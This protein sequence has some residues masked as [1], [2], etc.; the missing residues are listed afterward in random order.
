MTT[1]NAQINPS[2]KIVAKTVTL[3]DVSAESVGL[4]NVDNTSDINKPISIAAQAALDLKADQATTYTK[5][6]VDNNIANLVDTAPATLDTLN[7][8]AAALGDDANFATS[9]TDS[10]A[11]KASQTDLDT[12]IGDANNPHA[13]TA[14]QVGLGSVDNTADIDKPISTAQQAVL[15]DKSDVGHTHTESEITDLDK[16]T[17]AEAN[18][19]FATAAQGA[20]AD[21]ATQPSD[22][23]NLA[24]VSS[25][26]INFPLIPSLN[27]AYSLGST[28]KIW[29]LSY[30]STAHAGI[31]QLN[32]GT[33]G[34]T[35]TTLTRSAAGVLAVEGVDV[36]TTTTGYTQA[37]ANAAFATAAQGVL[38][39]TAAQMDYQYGS[40]NPTLALV[41]G[42]TTYEQ[43]TYATRLGYYVKI[44]KV[45]IVNFR[46][47]I[48]D[49]DSL[50]INAPQS[51]SFAISNMPYPALTSGI[52]PDISIQ[53]RQGWQNLGDKSY[54]G[55]IYNNYM[56]FYKNQ[57]QSGGAGVGLNL[58]NLTP[59]DF[60]VN[61]FNFV[62]S[63]GGAFSFFGSGSYI[64]NDD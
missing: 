20:L 19:A 59:S 6:E 57:T 12:H 46:I 5:A 39:D 52:A 25:G 43:T 49:P 35:D 23:G 37:A 16:Y 31:I 14:T 17:Q 47:K 28:S 22:L 42:E 30:F 45:V 2:T 33:A 62:E 64:T 34:T 3:H 55:V 50:M 32:G 8:L 27:G 41:S 53:P 58:S 9:V 51:S 26:A 54:S 38:A 11:T 56:Y 4:G 36:L 40:F 63:S 29:G 10:I 24:T 13:V 15:D 18:A 60:S 1:I 61:P 44:G 48:T 7:E 21:T